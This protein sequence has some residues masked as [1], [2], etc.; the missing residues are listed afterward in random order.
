[1]IGVKRIQEIIESMEVAE[2]VPPGPM[3]TCS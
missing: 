1:M 2:E 3:M